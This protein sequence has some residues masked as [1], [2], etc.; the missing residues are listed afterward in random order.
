MQQL[1]QNELTEVLELVRKY[2]KPHQP[3]PSDYQLEVIP[4]AVRREDDWLYVVVQPS[5]DGVRSNDYSSRL[6]EAELD[7][8][9]REGR[10]VLLVPAL[11]E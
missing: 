3:D 6:V 4:D 7:L 8:Q 2:L 10:K 9:E 1:D 5:R 11:P